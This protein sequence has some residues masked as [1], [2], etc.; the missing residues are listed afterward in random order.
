MLSDHR[1]QHFMSLK[2]QSSCG[3]RLL[4]C[5]FIYFPLEKK[6]RQL[7]FTLYS[8]QFNNK[9]YVREYTQKTLNCKFSSVQL[10]SRVRLFAT[11]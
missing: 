7:I 6:M 10:L 9:G 5:P 11:P 4:K 3:N 2:G 8:S 1:T